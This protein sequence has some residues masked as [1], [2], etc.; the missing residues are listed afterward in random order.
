MAHTPECALSKSQTHGWEKCDCF[1]PDT[2][3]DPGRPCGGIS[4][5]GAEPPWCEVHMKPWGH[6]RPRVATGCCSGCD[7]T[8]YSGDMETGGA[9]WDCQGTG[10]PHAG[11]CP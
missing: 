11:E 1:E 8:G 5:N 4:A 3:W 2:D 10:H 6:R 7:G 9:C